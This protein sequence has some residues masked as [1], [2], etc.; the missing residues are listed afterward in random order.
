MVMDSDCFTLPIFEKIEVKF[1]DFSW[2]E[3]AVRSGRGESVF[4]PTISEGKIGGRVVA[5]SKSK[6]VAVRKEVCQAHDDV[7]MQE[8]YRLFTTVW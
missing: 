6:A 2:R 7:L 1:T 4:C 8:G 5:S 3:I